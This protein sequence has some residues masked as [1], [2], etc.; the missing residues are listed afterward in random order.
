MQIRLTSVFRSRIA[1][2]LLGQ[3]TGQ[4]TPATASIGTGGSTN[5]TQNPPQD[6]MY[7]PSQACTVTLTRTATHE[8]QA[9]IQVPPASADTTYSEV[10][11]FTA[12]GTLILH[13]T[14]PTQTLTTG[15]EA[16]FRFTLNPE[17]TL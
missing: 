11:L 2:L 6:A 9:F 8:V 13:A 12:D 1:D 17:E 4:V 5:G 10:G 7:A 3:P 15:I 16:S 14:F